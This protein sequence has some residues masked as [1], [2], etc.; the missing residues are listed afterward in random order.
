[1]MLE[2]KVAM[3]TGA[4]AGIGVAI[5]KRYVAEGAKVCITGRRQNKL[6]EVVASL[7]A[8]TALACA[9]DVSKLED[10]KRMV[11]TTVGF[12][13]KIDI[14]INN[15]AIDPGGS[16]VDLDPDV[17]HAVLE[18]NLT[19]PFYTMKFAILHDRQR[20]GSIINISS[21]ACAASRPWRPTVHRRP[22]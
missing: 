21:P 18:T 6:N 7:P 2:G 19:G 9:G 4:G 13:G 3:I 20:G 17:W 11:D 1:M 22:D 5:A 16:V 14:L 10:A 15:A 8:G 12:G